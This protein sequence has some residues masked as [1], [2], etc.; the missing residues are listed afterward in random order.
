MS[1]PER[2][3]KLLQLLLLLYETWRRWRENPPPA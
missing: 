2:F 1:W 3:A